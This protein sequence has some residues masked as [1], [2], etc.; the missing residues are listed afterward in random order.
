MVS[1]K[2]S[3]FLNQ[4]LIPFFAKIS[5]AR[6][7][8]AL[9]DGM[10]A[11]VPM[12]IIGSVF[13]II[14]QF[15]WPGYLK[16]MAN[17]F[18]PNWANVVQYVTNASF[19]IMG[20]VAVAGIS[21]SLAKSYKVDAFSAMIVAIAAFIL[22]IPMQTA[23]DGSL[24]I[25]LK[26]FDS[27]GLF[28][29]LLV[30]LFVTDLYVW[31]VHKNLIF[32]MPDSVP[33]AVS[34][35]FAA[36]FPGGISLFVVWLIRIGVEATPMKSI[37]NVVTF[38]L[39]EPM[40][41]VG[42]T[43]G[44]AIVIE[45][46]ICILWI[47]GIHGANAISGIID[48][49]LYAALASNA[50]ALKAGKPIPNIVTKTFFDEFVRIGGCGAT[51]GLV[52]LMAF[53]AKSKELKAL[54]KLAIGPSIFNINEPVVFGLPIVLNYK[55]ILP[56]IFA[57]MANIIVTYFAMKTGLVAKTIGIYPPWTTPP[58]L[59]GILATGHLSGGLMQLFSLIMDTLIYFGF[60][61]S[62]DRDKLKLEK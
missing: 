45:L 37:P 60:F 2:K 58:I 9:R 3:D 26:D 32:K 57:P 62:I 6:H 39:Q 5:G 48:P 51:L 44:G 27:S 53:F 54:G 14:G 61:K 29:A 10:T 43:L 46:V 22:T 20:L 23:K 56:F 38:F 4:K 52:I 25:P 17:I 13:M 59:S 40:S 49:V 28:V 55:I 31:L 42:N 15:P 8:V 41:K 11:A 33:P 30:G 21:Y 12:I 47:F 18:G 7:M 36:L 16:F 50:T 24:L 35:S 1:N 34:N 19:H